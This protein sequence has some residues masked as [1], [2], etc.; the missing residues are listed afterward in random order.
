MFFLFHR[1]KLVEGIILCEFIFLH[2]KRKIF[3]DDGR[4]SKKT[5]QLVE[6][7][8]RIVRFA[9]ENVDHDETK[10]WTNDRRVFNFL[11]IRRFAA[12]ASIFTR[13]NLSTGDGRPNVFTFSRDEQ[14][15]NVGEHD[16]LFSS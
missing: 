5:E 6:I 8:R 4:T 14:Q 12:R 16:F 3:R 2:L 7:F 1:E 10:T 15:S 9:E 11:F 13:N